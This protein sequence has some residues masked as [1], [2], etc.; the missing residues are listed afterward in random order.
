MPC[1]YCHE[2]EQGFV[3]SSDRF[4]SPAATTAPDY[5]LFDGSTMRGDQTRLGPGAYLKLVRRPVGS[6]TVCFGQALAAD[7]AHGSAAAQT[8]RS[9][10][11]Q[12]G[13]VALLQ[14]WQ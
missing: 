11:L 3:S 12:L 7:A 8:G 13:R 9:S 10:R 6:N 4:A 2:H 5:S 14:G 1:P